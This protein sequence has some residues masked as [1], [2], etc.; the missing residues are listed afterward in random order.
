MFLKLNSKNEKQAKKSTVS[1]TP[2]LV[3]QLY[4]FHQITVGTFN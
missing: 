1:E 4:N 2:N 3:I